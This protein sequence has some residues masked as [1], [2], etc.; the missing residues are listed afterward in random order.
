MTP[1][2]RSVKFVTRLT[3]QTLQ[4][5]VRASLPSSESLVVVNSALSDAISAAGL[6]EILTVLTREVPIEANLHA[7]V[8]GSQE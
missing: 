7:Q 4:S 2:K 3:L 5:A 1:L 8:I 6:L